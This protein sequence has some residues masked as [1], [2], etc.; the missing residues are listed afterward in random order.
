MGRSF[1]LNAP[2]TGARHTQ[3]LRQCVVMRFLTPFSFSKKMKKVTLENTERGIEIHD[4]LFCFVAE[5]ARENEGEELVRR[6][7]ATK[8][9]VVVEFQYPDC[10]EWGI[11]TGGPNPTGDQFFPME[12]DVAFRLV[13]Y[14]A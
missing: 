6:F 13:N 8:N 2:T 14:F 9:L 11:S 3:H 12:K 4:E 1:E 10:T 7:N 5:C